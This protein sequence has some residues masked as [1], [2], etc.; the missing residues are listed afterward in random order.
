MSVSSF[1]EETNFKQW[2]SDKMMVQL[3]FEYADPYQNGIL[4]MI[5]NYSTFTDHYLRQGLSD[6]VL[7]LSKRHHF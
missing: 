1:S 2:V 4:P 5:G 3:T 7:T 6:I